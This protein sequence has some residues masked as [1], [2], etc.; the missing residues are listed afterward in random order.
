MDARRLFERWVDA[1]NTQ[2]L[3]T[4][5]SMLDPDFVVDYPQSGERIRGFDAFRRQ[6]EE[7]PAGLEPGSVATQTTQIVE[8]DER[9]AISPG[10]TVVPLAQPDRYTTIVR[11]GYPDGTWWQ[12]VSVVYLRAD[13]IYRIESYFAPELAAPLAQSIAAYGRG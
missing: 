8:G 10:Y 7:Y 12:T 6:V 5:E 3:P 4:L 9:W 1:L 13:R 2:D 11:I